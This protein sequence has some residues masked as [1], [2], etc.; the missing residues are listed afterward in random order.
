M[1]DLYIVER[2]PFVEKNLRVLY[3][4]NYGEKKL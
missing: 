2:F 4:E 1:L 3:N